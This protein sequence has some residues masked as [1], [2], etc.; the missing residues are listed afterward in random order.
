MS[1]KNKRK[2]PHDDILKQAD[3]YKLNTKAVDDLVNAN[4]ENSPPVSEKELRK[5]RSG[6]K[7]KLAEWVVFCLIKWWFAAACCFFFMWGLGNYVADQLDLLF[8]TSI[9]L[10]MV[11]DIL[12]NNA[13][14]FFE[15]SDKSADKWIMC[16]KRKSFATFPLNILYAIVLM[17]LVFMTYNVINFA[18]IR[19]GNLTDVLPLG[20]EPIMFG[21]FYL[22]WDLLFV[23]MRNTLKNVISDA[24]K[25]SH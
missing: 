24:R 7:I 14:R 21:L 9:G 25:P 18:I 2:D 8:V 3:Y 22:G 4:E 15:R 11:T 20:V 12:T 16:S 6:P 13:L 5:Y 1:K 10:G 23:A 19:I 17:F